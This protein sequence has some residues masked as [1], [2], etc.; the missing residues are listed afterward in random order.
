MEISW[1]NKIQVTWNTDRSYW[2][3][4]TKNDILRAFNH[5]STGEDR[6]CIHVPKDFMDAFQDLVVNINITPPHT[7]IIIV[8][9]KHRPHFDSTY[10]NQ[11]FKTFTDLSTD[12]PFEY[13]SLTVCLTSFRPWFGSSDMSVLH[14]PGLEFFDTTGEYK[15][16]TMTKPDRIM[17]PS[18]NTDRLPTPQPIWWDEKRVHRN[19]QG[20]S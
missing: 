2:S 9:N 19:Q 6:K 16:E 20:W 17:V 14:I 1:F 4:C 18:G 5:G 13:G 11:E 3:Y 7:P 15:G 10:E 12:L 8:W